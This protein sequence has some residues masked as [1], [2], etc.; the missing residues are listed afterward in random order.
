MSF[1]NFSLDFTSGFLEMSNKV[2]FVFR[3]KNIQNIFPLRPG[4]IRHLILHLFLSS[5]KQKHKYSLGHESLYQQLADISENLVAKVVVL[6]CFK[7]KYF[8][9]L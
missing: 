6:V 4:C 9:I 8:C 2:I 1:I 7:D 3:H 5:E